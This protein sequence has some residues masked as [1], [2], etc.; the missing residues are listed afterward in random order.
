MAEIVS[1][2]QSEEVKALKDVGNR[3]FQEANY[4]E[5]INYFTK[6][7]EI[8]PQNEVCYCNRSNAFYALKQ[9]QNSLNDAKMSVKLVDTYQKAHYRVIK[10]LL[11]LEQYKDAR[12]ALLYCFSQFGQKNK[13]FLQLESEYDLITK[14]PLRPKPGDFTILDELGNGNFSKIY[15]AKYKAKNSK[16]EKEEGNSVDRK[17][18]IKVIEKLTVEKM[19]RR[20]PNIN[21][22]IMM[23]K[24]VLNKLNHPNIVE[25]YATFQDDMTLYFQMEYLTGGEVWHMLLE[26]DADG[27][28]NQVGCHWSLI[29]FVIAECVNALEYMHRKGVVHRDIK[30]EN[31]VRNQYGHVKFVD[32][33]TAKDM[34]QT[35]LNGPEFVGT[36][37][38]MAPATLKSKKAGPEVDLWALG[39]V[40]YQLLLGYTPFAA[41]SPYLTFL[42]IKRSLV[43]LSD[44]IPANIRDFIKLLL[45]KDGDERLLN[46][47]GATA[48]PKHG[49]DIS[50]DALRDHAFFTGAKVSSDFSDPNYFSNREKFNK[51]HEHKANTVPSLTDLC[52]RAASNAALIL[53]DEMALNGGFRPSV[54]WMQ[55][56][57]IT[58]LSA[59]DQER[60]KHYLTRRN[61]LHNPGVYRL[62]HKS[63]VDARTIRVDQCNKEYIGYN[64]T[65]QG[66]W[67]KN[68]NFA[69][70][71]DPVIT[72]SAADL[73]KL[74]AVISS[75][76]RLRPKFIVV[77]GNFTL[78]TYDAD[79]AVYEEQAL[80]FRKTMA[81][82]SES[83]P[84]LFVPGDCD[85]GRTMQSLQQYRRL[86]GYDYYG[87]WYGGLRCLVI[88]STLLCHQVGTGNPE[89]D[90]AVMDQDIWLEEEIEQAKL[91][92]THILL[93][94]YHPWFLEHR[95]EEHVAGVNIPVTT[96][97]RWLDA[98]R[99][100]K[101]K[102]VFNGKLGKNGKL[103]AHPRKKGSSK[104]QEGD[105][106]LDHDDGEKKL[107]DQIPD[108]DNSDDERV[109]P[110]PKVLNP[111]DYEDTDS[112]EEKGTDEKGVDA[113]DDS[114]D[115]K[116][117]DDGKEDDE[118]EDDEWNNVDE[119]YYGPVIVSTTSVAAQAGGLQLI[120]VQEET[121]LTRFCAV[122]SIPTNL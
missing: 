26:E 21:N 107:S 43:K 83:I 10:G 48:K 20:H 30:P 34:V 118:E 62:F 91:C 49:S 122:D 45:T 19:K 2:N 90:N 12:L 56:F 17:Y 61:K 111:N 68:F 113:S 63:V 44:Y 64:R 29:R 85:V 74:K 97:L 94:S 9:Y 110:E 121:I 3:Y 14:I 79:A 67:N 28:R 92:S 93:F 46:A 36:P 38:Y 76:N 31:M 54:K 98:L 72:D 7:I 22:E 116:C 81:R 5:A 108:A 35:D 88:N 86:Y 80:L 117:K 70:I 71:T 50:Y 104:H 95:D 33:G 120:T 24:R 23:E 115:E 60:M 39:V 66:Q 27:I 18:A 40:M 112:D 51:I 13:E 65:M 73:E 58:R 89:L 6:A 69:Y 106:E 8:D 41:A 101:V 96:R 1:Q 25:L 100:S 52:I 16:N 53:A 87:F 32:F 42:R 37:E 11:A 47:I 99:H 78:R 114:K 59:A 102:F 57:D 4:E 109:I 82:V 105:Y 75:L 103:N 15:I 119:E 55:D 77:T 84:V